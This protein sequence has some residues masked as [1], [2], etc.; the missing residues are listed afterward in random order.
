MIIIRTVSARIQ[1]KQLNQSS[2]T[3]S[4]KI[5]IKFSILDI[6]IRLSPKSGKAMKYKE[7]TKTMIQDHLLIARN[8]EIREYLLSISLCFFLLVLHH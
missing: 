3:V 5:E 2:T 7:R 1:R 8:L 4:A 6:T